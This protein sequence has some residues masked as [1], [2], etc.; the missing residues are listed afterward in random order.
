[1]DEKMNGLPPVEDDAEAKVVT[2]EDVVTALT[3]A[4]QTVSAIV[5]DDASSLAVSEPLTEQADLEPE[6]ADEVA[7]R[8]SDHVQ[9]FALHLDL[10]D[11]IP[12]A[13]GMQASEE[14]EAAA[15]PS[16]PTAAPVHIEEPEEEDEAE[17][18]EE[19]DGEEEAPS[20]LTGCLTRILFALI[21]FAVSCVL[22]TVI[23]VF[24][25]D[26]TGW[27][28]SGDDVEI[29]IP[30]GANTVQVAEILEE[31][32]L[33]NEV[34]CFRIYSRIMGADGKWQA[35]A[36]TL[37][38]DMGFAGMIEALQIAPPRE[39]VTVL[40]RE[41]LTVDEM[42]VILEDSG[43]CSKQ[44]FLD[45][46]M[47]GNYDYDFIKLIPTEEDD[48]AYAYRVYRLEGYLFPDTYE[49]YVGSKGETVVDKMLAN[50]Q[51]KLTT[52][53]LEKIEAK[54]WTLDQA[55][56][57][58]SMVQGEGD[59]RENMDKVSRVLHNR[60]AP[61]SGFTKLELCCTRDY[62]NE[63]VEIHG[64]NSDEIHL[65]YN[66]YKREGFPIGAIGNPGMDALLAAVNP[67]EDAT[68]MKC[69]YFA[70]DYKTGTTYFSK[71]LREHQAIIKKYGITD[72][73]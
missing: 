50:F 12:D 38:G 20:K 73:G 62:A 4:E 43:V 42:A 1:M 55:I 67:S 48:P 72:L 18:P 27:T 23:S 63:I 56:I 13:E 45:A 71:T 52:G 60:L 33:I 39:T 40:L 51:S 9:Q 29:V 7:A 61:K 19:T 15:P 17:E 22:A 46:V 34:W 54:G 66:T 21:I 44:S 37:Q 31:N 64:F 14:E 57:F 10:D 41:G 49:F 36:F 24:L 65:A 58:A 28:G 11:D 5:T 53:L 25:F 59:T 26:A 70:T 30:D 68:I 35:G 32:E 3:E 6:I 47:Y 16:E 69:Y 2:E 8:R